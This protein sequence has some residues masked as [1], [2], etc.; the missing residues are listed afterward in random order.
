[1]YN[2]YQ[3]LENISLKHT[4][5]FVS[6]LYI[7]W[8]SSVTIASHVSLTTIPPIPHRVSSLMPLPFSSAT[9]ASFSSEKSLIKCMPIL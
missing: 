5:K 2:R 4:F 8:T 1:M 3:W 7:F 9:K 6:L